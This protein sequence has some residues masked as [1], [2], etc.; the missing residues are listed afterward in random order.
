MIME[1]IAESGPSQQSQPCRFPVL[2]TGSQGLQTE[3][4]RSLP[5]YIDHEVNLQRLCKERAI[6]VPSLVQLT[7]SI[8]LSLYTAE[9]QVKYGYKR[10]IGET[11]ASNEDVEEMEVYHL[12][13]RDDVPLR[14]LLNLSTDRAV[15]SPQPSKSQFNTS[16]GSIPDFNTAIVEDGLAQGLNHLEVNSNSGYS[17][18]K[19]STEATTT[20]YIAGKLLPFTD[21]ILGMA[22][23]HPCEDK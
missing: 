10:T 19:V 22:D 14:S 11:D 20:A 17:N 16:E 13:L 6:H 7:W 5:I 23:Y 9:K 3:K 12:E 2:N 1:M 21:G 18:V 4:V 15:Q 8:I